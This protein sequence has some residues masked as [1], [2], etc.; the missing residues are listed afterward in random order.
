ML[1]FPRFAR[2]FTC[3]V[4]RPEGV[5]LISEMQNVV[6][7]GERSIDLAE[8]ILRELPAKQMIA[9]LSVKYPKFD[10][11][12]TLSTWEMKGYIEEA[13]QHAAPHPSISVASIT[14]LSGRIFEDILA[15]AGFERADEDSADCL[16]VATDDY[17]RA[18]LGAINEAALAAK[19]PWLLT[20]PAGRKIWIGPLFRPGTGPCW[21]C[22]A[23]RIRTARDVEIYLAERA[24][25]HDLAAHTGPPAPQSV[26]SHALAA[27]H[28]AVYLASLTSAD[29]GRFPSELITID[30]VDGSIDKHFVVHR[31]QCPACGDAV[32]SDTSRSPAPIALHPSPKATRADGGHRIA[33][34]D[35]TV[36][37]YLHHVS[38]ISGAVTSLEAAADLDAGP[39]INV[40][41]AG[42]NLALPRS[43]LR[44][45]KHSLRSSSGGKGASPIQAKAS[46]LCEA[47]ERFSGNF[48]G[49]EPRR[50][51]RLA[52][53]GDQAV[54]PNA[55]TLFSERQFRERDSWVARGS[56]F[57]TVPLP[58]EESAEMEWSPVWSMTEQRHKFLLTQMLYFGYPT[59]RDRFFTWADSN[60]CAAGNTFEEAIVQG[61]CELIERDA[62]ATWWYPRV[63]RPGVDLDSFGDPYVDQLRERYAAMNREIWALDLT[64]DTGI[65]VVASLSRRTDKDCEEII[66]AFGAHFDP[67]I[68][69]IRS[70]AEMNQFLPA[71][72]HSDRDGK[73]LYGDADASAWWRE[74]TVERQPYLLPSGAPTRKADWTDRSSDDTRD[75][76]LTAQQAVEALGLEMLVLD[77]TRPDIGLPVARVI[78]PG[79]RHFWARYA[80]G[81]LY[82]VPV[83]LGWLSEPVAEED[84]NPIAIFI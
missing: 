48:S 81:R 10:L 20:R 8:A 37:R 9:D 50:A 68:A 69:L 29:A 24:E 58:F 47:L 4:L 36:A 76:V 62:V 6:L 2:D 7:Q 51:G 64:S 42:Q 82:D 1:Q 77:Q 27:A 54:H 12:V 14:D 67:R 65:P 53:F 34:P 78:V 45:L 75:D 55:I 32:L 41:H 74:E 49:G 43:D 15:G 52:D 17:L 56:I 83:K 21:E 18:E 66:F 16:V 23:A 73:Y 79:L 33:N 71:V 70:L 72:I 13:G 63:S 57:N 61:F 31:P 35:D 59:T 25:Q 19:R 26:T 39:L 38:P 22:L 5:Y 28:A 80:P 84:L 60:G 40:V 44:A 11:M 3:R 30:Q 46:G